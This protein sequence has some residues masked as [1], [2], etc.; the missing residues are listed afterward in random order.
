MSASAAFVALV[1]A[2]V[3]QAAFLLARGGR[4]PL[5]RWLLLAAGLLSL[6]AILERSVLIR[7]VAVTNTFE[8]L[9]FFSGVLALLLFA[10]T[11]RGRLVPAA[12]FGGTLVAIA[13]LAVASS[14]IAPRD[15]L[16]PV[17]ALQSHWLLLH[18]TF[19][20]V[21]EAFFAV[22]AVSAACSLAAKDEQRRQKAERAAHNAI[23]LGFPIFTAGA[24]VFG[25]I[26]AQTAWGAWWSWDPKET[27]AL[28]T[29]LTYTAYLHARLAPGLRGRWPPILAIAGFALTLFT[30]F[31]VNFLLPGLHSYR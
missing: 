31:G 27:W 3:S 11:V 28:I 23:A 19:A 24:L 13:L 12:A 1:L 25:A 16:P 15:V 7:F 10:Y 8:S 14:P 26:W 20:F 30:F 17:P 18:V 21:G 2:A 22:A 9:V 6:A 4:D 5:S 29:W